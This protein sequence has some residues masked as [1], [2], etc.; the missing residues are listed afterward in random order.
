[1]LAAC[2]ALPLSLSKG[3][4]DTQPPIGAP[5]TSGIAQAVSHHR[6]FL[7]TGKEQS[8]KVPAGVK[9]I[10]V[11][12]LGAA[13]GGTAA[14]RGGRVFAE[15]PVVQGERLALL[16]GGT[17]TSTSGGYNG[18][19]QAATR[20]DSNQGYGGGGA[21][22]IREPGKSL[23]HRILVAGGGG[24]GG[25]GY[26]GGGG[27]GGKGGGSTAAS[28][29]SGYGND[30]SEARAGAAARRIAAE[31]VDWPALATTAAGTPARTVRAARVVPEALECTP[32]ALEAAA[33]TTEAAVAAGVPATMRAAVEVVARP[34]SS[35]Q[36]ENIRAGEV[37]KPPR[38]TVLS[39]LAGTANE[40]LGALFSRA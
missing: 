2:G 32:A 5:D 38:A 10:T 15:F 17:T 20:P 30:V 13:G 4:D 11:D 8:F 37:G 40:T 6:T 31:A 22:D 25:G 27:D 19:G 26:Y 28:G 12:A 1:M 29:S 21:T 39:F 16:V 33:V 23:R 18:G 36:P 34:I 35:Q 14:G 24:G 3:Q 9:W 7:Y